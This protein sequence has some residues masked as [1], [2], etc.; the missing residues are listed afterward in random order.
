[1]PDLHTE[2]MTESLGDMLEVFSTEEVKAFNVSVSDPS[3]LSMSDS[4]Y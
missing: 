3:A 1:M 4:I 2:E